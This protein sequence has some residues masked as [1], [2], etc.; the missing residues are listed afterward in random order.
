[1]ISLLASPSVCVIDDEKEEYEV[2]L[3]ALN[4]LR[5]PAHHIKGTDVNELPEIGRAHV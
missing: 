4:Q 2:I 3:G 5:V 1:M